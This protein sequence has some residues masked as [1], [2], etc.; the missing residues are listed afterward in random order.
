MSK[1]TTVAK[2][3]TRLDA[4]TTGNCQGDATFVAFQP[5]GIS[6]FWIMGNSHFPKISTVPQFFLFPA[7]V[8]SSLDI[9]SMHSTIEQKYEKIYTAVINLLTTSSWIINI[10]L[11]VSTCSIVVQTQVFY[12]SKNARGVAQGG[13]FKLQFDWYIIEWMNECVFIYRTYH[14]LSQGGLQC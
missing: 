10:L 12:W 8:S 4:I 6:H 7:L 2:H 11:D 9:L 13:M 3:K 14:I 5:M 1:M